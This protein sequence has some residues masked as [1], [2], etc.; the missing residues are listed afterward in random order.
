M[1]TLLV[2]KRE[3]KKITAATNQVLLSFAEVQ[4]AARTDIN[5]GTHDGAF[6]DG[7][8]IVTYTVPALF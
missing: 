3:S 6:T 8:N 5:E 1:R 2:W 7:T 4:T